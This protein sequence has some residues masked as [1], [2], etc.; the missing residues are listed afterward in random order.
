VRRPLHARYPTGEP[1]DGPGYECWSLLAALAAGVERLQLGSLVSPSTVHHPA[2][3][4]KQATTIDEVSGGRLVLGIGAGWQVN[5]HR[6]YGYD[7]PPPKK[8][9]DRFAEF[10]EILHGLLTQPRTTFSGRSFTMADAPCEPKGVQ[11]PIP[12]MVGTGSP[13]MLRLTAQW[14]QVWNTWGTPERLRDRMEALD[15]ACAK[16]GRD[17]GTIRRT[18]QALVFMVDDEAKA[19]T[20]RERAPA[21]RSLIGTSAEIADRVGE[22]AAAGVDE[23][24]VPDFSLGRTAEDRLESYD[25]FWS[26]IASVAG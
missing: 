14:A 19:K 2:L 6:A 8:R 12:I 20:L 24:I 11:G 5:E 23:F 13:R 21:D 4:A 16:V 7:L 10:I 17:P 15:A 26:E 22:Y 9:V 1:D 18:A 3:L 25:R